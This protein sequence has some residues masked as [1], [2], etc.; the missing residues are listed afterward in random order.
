MY[1][2]I[3]PVTLIQNLKQD[4]MFPISALSIAVAI[5]LLNNVSVQATSLA[6]TNTK[7]KALQTLVLNNAQAN[8]R[9]D[10]SALKQLMKLSSY[11][12]S[13]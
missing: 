6:G 10:S 12:K 2:N 11:G 3:S 7:L 1:Y 5:S 4:N 9:L 13:S 8:V